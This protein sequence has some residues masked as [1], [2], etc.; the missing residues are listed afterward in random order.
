MD[1]SYLD[2]NKLKSAML[3]ILSSFSRNS[4]ENVFIKW[5]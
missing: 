4:Y 5:L 1:E 2:S 3:N